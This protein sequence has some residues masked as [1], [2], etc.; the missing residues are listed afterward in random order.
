MIKR[1]FVNASRE[2]RLAHGEGKVYP[3]RT[4]LYPTVTA[5][6]AREDD[7]GSLTWLVELLVRTGYHATVTREVLKRMK[8]G[9]LKRGDFPVE[10]IRWRE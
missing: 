10:K 7:L 9:W 5:L 8:S 1:D 4:G 2:L 3:A 6:L